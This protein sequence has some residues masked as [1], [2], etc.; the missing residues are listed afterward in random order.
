MQG[1]FGVGPLEVI[2]ILVLVLLVFGPERLP[3]L[4]RNLGNAIRRLKETYVAFVTEFRD[5]LTPIATEIDAATRDLRKDLAEI[6]DA[7][8]IRGLIPS[9]T[10]ADIGATKP[11][12]AAPPPTPASPPVPAP[13]PPPA[14]ASPATT[15]T[16]AE[17][18][19]KL[20]GSTVSAPV[21]SAISPNGKNGKHPTPRPAPAKIDLPDDNPWASLGVP[22]RSDQLDEDNPWRN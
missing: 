13:P 21:A 12:G 1:I 19:S 3:E 2:F 6:R 8:D 5:E 17:I 16:T 15:L 14:I 7:A 10:D 20:F 18:E 22:I 9:I 11:E 4:T